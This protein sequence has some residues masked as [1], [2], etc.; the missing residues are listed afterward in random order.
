MQL[1]PSTLLRVSAI[2]SFLVFWPGFD[3]GFQGDD[4]VALRALLEH[5]LWEISFVP[6]RYFPFYRPGAVCQF[7]GE[8]SLFGLHSGL[9]LAANWLLH[10]GACLLFYRLACVLGLERRPAAVAASLLLVGFAHYGKM[11]LWATC[12]PAILCE[13][14]VLLALVLAHKRPVSRAAAAALAGV[15]LVAPL[16]HEMGKLAPFIILLTLFIREWRVTLCRHGIMAATL[17]PAA[18]W[19]V[20]VRVLQ[21][22]YP[23]YGWIAMPDLAILDRLVRF[24]G[25]FLLPAQ[26]L[27]FTHT[28]LG[29]FPALTPLASR[30]HFGLGCLVL[31]GGLLLLV[32]GPRALRAPLA[33][34]AVTLLAAAYV[35]MESSWLERRYLYFAAFPFA[36]VTGWAMVRLWESRHRWGRALSIALCAAFVLESVVAVRLLE[37]KYDAVGHDPATAAAMEEIRVL[38]DGRP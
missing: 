3:N 18:A 22:W 28:V 25:F 38:Y 4:F 29:K 11:L 9:F 10:L 30:I 17:I 36:A 20:A 16:F 21:P 32:R 6:N 14:L 26:S 7:A 33:W 8:L 5:G 34:C 12:G 15:L 2:I 19:V 27:A 37:R 23:N 31:L 24:F 35:P 1:K 13:I